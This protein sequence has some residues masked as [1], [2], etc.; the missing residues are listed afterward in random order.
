MNLSLSPLVE[1][2]GVKSNYFGKDLKNIL[3]VGCISNALNG[4]KS[5]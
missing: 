1:K 5:T 2:R 4:K 3:L